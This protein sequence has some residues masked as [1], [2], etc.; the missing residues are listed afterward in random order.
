MI[1]GAESTMNSAPPR[2][3][4]SLSKYRVRKFHSGAV[5]KFQRGKLKIPLVKGAARKKFR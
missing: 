5:K 4:L 3:L 2:R 1:P